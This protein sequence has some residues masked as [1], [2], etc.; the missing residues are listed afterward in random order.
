[1]DAQRVR[2]QNRA[3]A[4]QPAPDFARPAPCL[5]SYL[6]L[7]PLALP[8]YVEGQFSPVLA[9]PEEVNGYEDENMDMSKKWSLAWNSALAPHQPP[10]SRAPIRSLTAPPPSEDSLS[11]SSRNTPPRPC[12]TRQPL[13]PLQTERA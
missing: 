2:A 10:T 1:M 9:M 3:T 11:S 4:R 8:R 6:T 7:P 12:V 5:L 13:S